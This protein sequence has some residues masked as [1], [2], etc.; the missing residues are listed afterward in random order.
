MYV[1]TSSW[2]YRVNTWIGMTSAVL[3]T[4]LFY[5]KIQKTW[6]KEELPTNHSLEACTL[7]NQDSLFVE[8]PQHRDMKTLQNEPRFHWAT[9]TYS[10]PTLVRLV[11]SGCSVSPLHVV[12]C[13]LFKRHKAEL[14]KCMI[15]LCSLYFIFCL[16]L[17]Y[18]MWSVAINQCLT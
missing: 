5:L 10:G 12:V 2:G 18:R 14:I 6:K 3:G 8:V 16:L 7:L 17:L 1:C 9:V 4:T 15:D 11:F 13:F